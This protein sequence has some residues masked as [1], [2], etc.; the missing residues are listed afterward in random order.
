MSG[1]SLSLKGEGRGEGESDG[2]FTPSP[3]LS[4]SSGRGI[5]AYWT[6]SIEDNFGGF[7]AT[8]R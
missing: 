8:G 5:L 1:N 2:Y 7:Y 3:N 6:A 4:P